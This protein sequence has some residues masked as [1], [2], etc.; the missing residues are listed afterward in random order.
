[1]IITFIV[2]STLIIIF[3]DHRH[4]HGDPADVETNQQKQLM[5]AKATDSFLA[6]L[7]T[8]QYTLYS[9]LYFTSIH[10]N[11]LY[12]YSYL[13]HNIQTLKTSIGQF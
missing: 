11:A 6:K 3:I 1:M 13:Y 8:I 5:E 9:T 2:I 7:H 10:C 4:P 12:S